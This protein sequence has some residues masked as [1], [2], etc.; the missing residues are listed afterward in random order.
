MQQVASAV[1]LGE[2]SESSDKDKIALREALGER[3]G[4]WGGREAL[5][6]W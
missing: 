6:Y 1:E 4:L 2:K 5:G 3:K